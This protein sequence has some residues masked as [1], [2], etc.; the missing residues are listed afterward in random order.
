[1]LLKEFLYDEFQKYEIEIFDGIDFKAKK[2][3]L[4]FLLIVG[5]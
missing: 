2:N 3:I 1:M 4:I 5:N